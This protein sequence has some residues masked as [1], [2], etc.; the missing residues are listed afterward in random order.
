MECSLRQVHI[1][2]FVK[3]GSN[4]YLEL[5]V[6]YFCVIAVVTHSFSIFST[7][8]VRGSDS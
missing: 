7:D 2:D 3:R 5:K 1:Q 6:A 4:F 8:G